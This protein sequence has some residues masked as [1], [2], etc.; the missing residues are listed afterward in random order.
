[1]SKIENK[2]IIKATQKNTRQP[3]RKV[4][5]VAN[6]VK[7]LSL[8]Q[9]VKQLAVIQRKSTLVVLKVLRQ[10]IANAT[11]NHGFAVSDLSIKS[12]TVA[13]APILK[14]FR[15]VSRG[16]AHTILKRTCHVSVELLAQETK[17]VVNKKT[18]DKKNKVAKKAKSVVNASAKKV[19]KKVSSTKPAKKKIAKA[20]SKK[21]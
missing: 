19:A 16:R 3:A 6:S 18:D 20:K 2:M 4:R 9:A 21:E 8:E 11:H 12:I 15:A 17:T 1:M 5:I 10:A 13:P 7:D 14:R